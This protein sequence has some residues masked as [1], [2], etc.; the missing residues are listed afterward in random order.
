MLVRYIAYGFQDQQ[1]AKG[2]LRVQEYS[3][4][5]IDKH[6]QRKIQGYSHFTATVE[7]E[8]IKK[9]YDFADELLNFLNI[10]K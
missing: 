5:E 6:L 3:E 1:I 4:K 9:D 2:T 10:K 7:Q 8:P